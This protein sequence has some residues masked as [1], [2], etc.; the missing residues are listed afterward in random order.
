MVVP[1]KH[2]DELRKLPA[3]VLSFTGATSEVSLLLHGA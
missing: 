1:R 2:L 3:Q